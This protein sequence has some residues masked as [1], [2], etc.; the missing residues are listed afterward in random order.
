[1]LGL[2][3]HPDALR[4][5][6]HFFSGVVFRGAV[7]FIVLLVVTV[8]KKIVREWNWLPS[9]ARFFHRSAVAHRCRESYFSFLGLYCQ[10]DALAFGRY[11]F[12]WP[13]L[14]FR[15]AAAGGGADGRVRLCAPASLFVHAAVLVASVLVD[16]PLVH[17]S[18]DYSVKQESL[19]D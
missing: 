7:V 4:L 6:A 18:H 19:D 3:C 10:R 5:S 13:R 11:G 12:G 17:F 16:M 8:R 2:C 9:S 15:A 1:M 14:L